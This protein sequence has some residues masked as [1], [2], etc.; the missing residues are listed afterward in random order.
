MEQA[1]ASSGL[2]ADES[3][4]ATAPT[5]LR[6]AWVASWMWATAIVCLHVSAA[7]GLGIGVA[8]LLLMLWFTRRRGIAASLF[9]MAALGVVTAA[10]VTG[11]NVA[12][13][14]ADALQTVI[15]DGANGTVTATVSD[16]P[17]LVLGRR[18]DTFV[19]PVQLR[20]I[21]VD[22]DRV[23]TSAPALVFASGAGSQWQGLLPRQEISVDGWISRPQPG[24]DLTA[25]VISTREPP[26]T[27]GEPPWWQTMAGDLRS[28]LRT[29]C[30][31][32]PDDP[33]GLI[34]GLVLGDTSGIDYTLQDQ[35]RDTGMTHLVAV[36]G[37]NIAVVVTAVILLA[38]LSRASR[39]TQTAIGLI[40]IVSFVVLVRP[41]PSV[42]RAAVM[43]AIAL[44]M[45][46]ARRRGE[47]VAVL[48]VTVMLLLCIDPALACNLGFVLS[49]VATC[50]LVVFANHWAQLW[51]R[52]GWPR[53]LAVAVAVPVA[54]QVAVTPVLAGATGSVSLVAIPANIVVAPVV[55]AVMILG[56][57]ATILAPWWMGAAELFA[58]LASW[59]A[60]WLVLVAKEGSG[61]TAGN[62]PWPVGWW[63]GIILAV[64]VVLA[65]VIARTRLGRRLLL[66]VAVGIVV[67]VLPVRLW[68][69][70]WPPPGWVL[71]ACDVGQG[72][73]LVLATAQA[74]T[75][76]VVDTGSQPAQIDKC[77]RTLQ[78]DHVALLVIS[79]FH[80]DH[81][82]G[83][84]G[85]FK[86]RQVDAVMAPEVQEP[87]TGHQLLAESAAGEVSRP[88]RP[89]S[90]QVVAGVQVEALTP[91]REYSG[92]NSDPNNNSL[93]MRFTVAGVRI[94]AT[95]DIEEPAQ[96]DL[97]DSG[98]SV[99]ADILKVP[100]HG[101]RGFV[102]EFYA[103]VA[104]SVAIISVG[105]GNDYGHPHAQTLTQLESMHTKVQRTDQLGACAVV[106]TPEGAAVTNRD[107]GDDR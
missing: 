92:T 8:A 81:V 73:G 16:D 2:K 35:F 96:Q 103:A 31:P 42:L 58:W 17:R 66:V 105:A 11:M 22:G 19:I 98:R 74:G 84:S 37:S 41:S 69:G 54:A 48:S 10:L 13:K 23:G 6:L 21:S 56:V 55:P 104:P 102:P 59:P 4:S 29:A 39:G 65:I 40:T 5:D 27:E 70:G 75:A 53:W 79:H 78:I 76:I 90:R 50:G 85:V 72:D 91:T 83:I 94:L 15:G 77:L 38:K 89:G 18:D 3:R 99:R 36:S 28:G 63:A 68:H 93:V 88:P 71:V 26:D 14:D 107:S 20:S 100:H 62:V 106:K 67:G 44:L 87:E 46:L 32:L 80:D 25:A 51:E 61:V 1:C 47:P 52:H 49:V 24:P 45:V 9:A 57:L 33:G 86:D 34:P 43:G 7:V 82:G 95:G 97:L 64:I 30:E 12:V 101:S 60:R